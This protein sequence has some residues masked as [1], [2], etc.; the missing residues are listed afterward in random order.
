MSKNNCR[1]ENKIHNFI[2]SKNN[3]IEVYLVKRSTKP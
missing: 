3:T 2:L 1:Y